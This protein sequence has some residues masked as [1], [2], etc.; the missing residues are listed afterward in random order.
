MS[1]V[2]YQLN[3]LNPEV[4]EYLQVPPKAMQ[5]VAG[6]PLSSPRRREDPAVGCRGTG[7]SR[8][9]LPRLARVLI[10]GLGAA[11]RGSSVIGPQR[12]YHEVVKP[13]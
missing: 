9:F 7:L 12:H 6:S 1:A 11:V 4:A 8:R 13:C 5:C 10:S 2:N 3:S